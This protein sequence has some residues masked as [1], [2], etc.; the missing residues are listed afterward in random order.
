MDQDVEDFEHDLDS[1]LSDSLKIPDLDAA[2]DKD[3]TR[4]SSV[5]LGF[6]LSVNINSDICKLEL[7]PSIKAYK[8][9]C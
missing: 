5:S 8:L 9:C 3:E 2:F 1:I 6:L 4:L 7:V